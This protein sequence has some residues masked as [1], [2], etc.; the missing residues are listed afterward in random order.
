MAVINVNLDAVEERE[1]R[2]HQEGLLGVRVVDAEIRDN[3]AKD[4]QY[5]NWRLDPIE[6]DNN[7]PV[8]LMTSLK[9][10][11]LW[12]LKRFLKECGFQWESDGG[13]DTADVLGSEVYVTVTIE[14]YQGEPRNRV[15]MPYKAMK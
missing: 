12:N 3:K 15:G 10:D 6:G 1:R 11:A 9:P 7:S 8:W 2:V 5:I 4:G 13:F 14:E